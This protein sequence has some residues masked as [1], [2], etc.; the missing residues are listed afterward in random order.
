[1]FLNLTETTL[2]AMNPSKDKPSPDIAIG[3]ESFRPHNFT[4]GIHNHLGPFQ[5]LFFMPAIHT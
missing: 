3:T 5:S 1:M 4:S 2:V